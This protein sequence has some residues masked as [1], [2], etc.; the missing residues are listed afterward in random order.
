MRNVVI[1]EQNIDFQDQLKDKQQAFYKCVGN[2][3]S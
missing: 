2:S 1:D 3:Q